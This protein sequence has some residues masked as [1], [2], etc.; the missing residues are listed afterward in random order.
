M[1]RDSK[2]CCNLLAATMTLLYLA[3]SFS[4]HAAIQ[5]EDRSVDLGPAYS[6]ET[7]GVSWGDLNDDDWPDVAVSHH[8]ALPGLFV[9]DGAGSFNDIGATVPTWS[10][11]PMRDTHGGSWADFD[12]DG[13][14]DFS[15]TTG[16]GNDHQFF[17][18]DAGTLVDRTTQYGLNYSSW[19][20]RLPVW[21]DYD[22]DGKL[23]FIVGQF[24]GT[25][26][27]FR[28]TASGFSN[29]TGATGAGC[30]YTTYAQLL[31]I[32]ND[33]RMDLLCARSG[34]FP[35][36]AYSFTTLPF[37]NITGSIP[38]V[39]T[40]I[41]T[42]LGDF[43]RNLQQ[44]VFYVRSTTRQADAIQPTANTLE[45]AL[46]DGTKGVKFNSNGTVTVDI[47]WQQIDGGDYSKIKIGSSGYSPA[48]TPFALNPAN[49]SNWGIKAHNS[50]DSPAIYFGYNNSTGQWT[51]VHF[52]GGKFS[53]LYLQISST[54]AITGLF[55]TGF[56]SAD[57]PLAPVLHLN[58]N[59]NFS[60]AANASNISTPVSCS[61]VITADLDNDMDLDLFLTCRAG[62]ENLPNVLYENRGNSVFD[63]VTGAG[64][65]E[66]PQ[67]P[68]VAS[69]AG[70]AESVAAA[71]YDVDGFIDLFVT[72]GMN[73]RPEHIGGP[74]KLYRNMGNSNRWVEIDLNGTT[75]NRDG[76]GARVIATAGGVEQLRE[77]NG[78][79][80]RWSQN[81]QRIHFGLANN[82]TVDLRIEWPGGV[83]DS[84]ANVAANQ[85]Y[86]A[87]EGGALDVIQVG[88]GNPLEPTLN[89]GDASVQEN[90]TEAVF[91]VTLSPLAETPVTVNFATA[92]G[93]AQAGSDY[94]SVNGTLMF[95]TGV[96][97]Q[98]IMVP[99]IDDEVQEN[100]ESFTVTL[101]N[102]VD[103]ILGDDNGVGTI[104]DNELSSCG[105]PAY[106]TAVDRAVFIWR[107]CPDGPWHIRYT[108]GYDYIKYIGNVSSTQPFASIIPY[109]V[110]VSD[111]F[112]TSDPAL[113][114]YQLQLVPPYEDGYELTGAPGANICFDLETPAGIDVF[115]GADRASAPVMPLELTS[116]GPC[117]LPSVPTLSIADVSAPEG[118]ERIDFTVSL[119]PG[120]SESVSVNYMTMDGDALA[121]SDYTAASGT[122]IIPALETSATI[123][124]DVTNDS[125]PEGNES[126]T[127]ALSNEINAVLGDA[128][129]TGTIID[130]ETSVC[131]APTYDQSADRAIFLWQ[132][133]ATGIWSV[134]YTAAGGYI[135]YQG[136]VVADQALTS[137]TPLSIESSDVLDA[138][139]NPTRIDYTLKISPPYY[140]GYDFGY[141]A[142]TDIC[143][144]ITTPSSPDV[145]IGPDRTPI[146]LPFNLRTMGPCT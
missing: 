108:G 143:F 82:S 26:Q 66:G 14:D 9:N 54:A 38:Q 16:R 5:F 113:L 95:D 140:D 123:P 71:D 13:D 106:S 81:H 118:N 72:N 105:K 84:H 47:D 31:D 28:Q 43:D 40:V 53:N 59:G 10:A 129:A 146:T 137:F 12:N 134:R 29:A 65:A 104:I 51:A 130:D 139:S 127:I 2:T 126:F 145:M 60:N 63:M 8:R 73:M 36:R 100:S 30:T 50:S 62:A 121:G 45:V 114:D 35:H 18:N 78:G 142:D 37:G 144:N 119:L 89:I 85:L 112:D 91:D 19:A 74:N 6:G 96:D 131:G 67:G 120:S 55:P 128:N 21:F 110:E 46:V 132:D 58:N 87:T 122:L 79:S 125:D 7:Y 32:N 77:Q 11:K 93:N 136:S 64:G 49:S 80:H 44:D 83:I 39:S 41:D 70:T 3:G 99:I 20:G 22:N 25:S 34:S 116:L 27:V 69:G 23:D 75:S 97:L 90:A 109:S 102:P 111:I 17:V 101:T 86:R 57:G 15:L 103:A 115:I 42:A 124:I 76:I 68:A 117:G 98:Q 141:P 88:G 4:A 107:D 33:G 133:C 135:K 94:S 92:D 52:T 1:S 61:S 56:G 138:A 24:N 48:S